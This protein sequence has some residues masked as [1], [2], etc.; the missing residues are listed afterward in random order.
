MRRHVW[1]LALSV[2]VLLVSSRIVFSTEIT[3]VVWDDYYNIILVTI[4]AWPGGWNDWTMYVDGF[5]MPVQEEGREL[6]V[7]TTDYIENSPTELAIGT[8]DSAAGA[9]LDGLTDVDFPCCGTLQFDIPGQGLTNTYEFSVVD[10]GCDTASAKTCASGEWIVHDGDLVVGGTDT[11]LI[12]DA[13]YFQRGNI[14]VND[15]ATLIVRNSELMMSRGDLP[16]IHVY[17]FVGPDATLI[18]DVASVYPVTGGPPPGSLA[19]VMNEGTAFMTDSE[20]EIHYFDVAPGATFEMTGSS[21]VNDI[22][23]LLQ[24]AGGN[25]LVTDSTLGALALT[26]PAGAHLDVSGLYSGVYFESWDVHDMIPDA[27]Y[28][29]DLV[30]TTILEDDFT[31]ELEHG[32]YERGWIFILDR[33]AHACISDSELRKVFI[34][35]LVDT[36]EFHDLRVDIPSS[37]TFRDIVLTDVVVTGE[38]PFVIQN[39]DVTFYNS[40]YLFLQ[41]SQWATVTLDHSHMVEFIPR[42]FAGTMVCEDASWTCAGEFTYGSNNFAMTGSLAMGEELRTNLQFGGVVTRRIEVTCT[43]Q[44]GRALEGLTIETDCVWITANRGTYTTDAE[45]RA[46]FD[47]KYVSLNYAHPQATYVPTITVFAGE[48][49]LFQDE[50]DFFVTTPV[51]IQLDVSCTPEPNPLTWS[52]APHTVGT[53]SVEMTATAATDPNGVEYYFDE[54]SGNPGATDSGWQDSP[55]YTDSGLQEATEYCYQVKARDKSPDQNETSWSSTA[56]AITGSE[57]AA[58]FRVTET[59]DLF[60]DATVFAT[61]FLAGSA[62]IAEW[63]SISDPVRPGDVLVFDANLPGAYRRSNSPCSELVAGVVSAEPGVILGLAEPFEQRALLA[64]VGVV[65]VIVTNES[66]PILPGDLL[67]SSSTLVHAMRWPGPDP[68]PCSLVGKALE[69]MADETGVILVLLTAH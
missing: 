18:L 68:C 35:M 62:D 55:T 49:Q 2:V 38:W 27:G 32:P 36:A 59:G 57:A 10:F 50:V 48:E 66:G 41:P 15:S 56:C 12:E 47:I 28:D 7:Y 34:D 54:T 46:E 58:V 42:G 64:L 31:G 6:Y 52:T 5:G 16:T 61:N 40:E 67:V 29:L 44:E 43:D 51:E 60:C 45:G 65:P 3:G 63:V 1:G 14:Y 53:D 39:G 69:P 22:G 19:C 30:R 26:V 20:T 23:G 4:D 21:M 37:L 24:I 17:I 13:K 33:D 11:F 25:T 8:R 9:S